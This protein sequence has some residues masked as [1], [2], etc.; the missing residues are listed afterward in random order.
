MHYIKKYLFLIIAG[1]VAIYLYYFAPHLDL[2]PYP[3][4]SAALLFMVILACIFKVALNADCLAEILGDPY[5]TLILT[6][7]ATIIEVSVMM[8]AL[9]HGE[10]NPGFVRDMIASTLFIVI[11]GMTGLSMMIGGFLHPDQNLNTHGAHM[12]LSLLIPL[13]IVTLILPNFTVHELG[14][15]LNL[16]QVLFFAT[17]VMG[18]YGLFIYAQT[19]RHQ[20]FFHDTQSFVLA[21]KKTLEDQSDPNTKA[22]RVNEIA[23]LTL[24]LSISLLISVL[25]IE[26]LSILISNEYQRIGFPKSLNGITIAVLVLAPELIA[27]L[28][29]ARANHLQRS[30]NIA[31]GSGIATLSLTVP[32]ILCWAAFNH[33]SIELGLPPAQVLLLVSSLWVAHVAMSTGKSNLVQGAVLFLFFVITIFLIF[34]P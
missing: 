15:S 26:K 3:L 33:V 31:L 9:T 13:A 32:I 2:I 6:G 10:G 18:V 16:P 8:T 34:N 19:K 14:T 28:N 25:L 30:L 11:G 21:R 12:Y 5:G 24:W 7:A 4:A 27:S 29:A 23:H 17:T 20:N 1:C 22:F